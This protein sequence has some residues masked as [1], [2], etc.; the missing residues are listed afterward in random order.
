M[1]TRKNL[2]QK[3]FAKILRRYDADRSWRSDYQNVLLDDNNQPITDQK[4][5]DR[6]LKSFK[7]ADWYGDN[8][9]KGEYIKGLVTKIDQ[10]KDEAEV[11][12]GRYKAIVTAKDMGKSGKKPA[13]ELKLG[14]LAGI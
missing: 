9:A 3:S 7:H 12:F 4:E 6:T 14:Y 11:R 10:A 2:L 5:I 8:Y 13:S 1:S